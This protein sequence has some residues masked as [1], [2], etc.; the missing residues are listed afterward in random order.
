MKSETNIFLCSIS[1][2]MLMMNW[3]VWNSFVAF[4]PIADTNLIRCVLCNHRTLD[5]SIF[6]LIER[7]RFGEMRNFWRFWSEIKNISVIFVDALVELLWFYWNLMAWWCLVHKLRESFQLQSFNSPSTTSLYFL[8]KDCGVS[9]PPYLLTR[10]CLHSISKDWKRQEHYLHVMFAQ[11][12]LITINQVF[13]RNFLPASGNF[14][15]IFWRILSLVCKRYE[16]FRVIFFHNERFID[17]ENIDYFAMK[18]V[19]GS[20]RKRS[21]LKTDNLLTFL[22]FSRQFVCSFD[23]NKLR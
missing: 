16:E 14:L 21:I 19:S 6:P 13:W 1:G 11:K 18:Q 7:I 20:T 23:N 12:V 2:I 10:T 22:F 8:P 9:L 5:G 3:F 4:D 17:A 15:V